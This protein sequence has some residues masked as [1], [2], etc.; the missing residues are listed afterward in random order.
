[1]SA[2]DRILVAV[3]ASSAAVG[4]AARLAARSGGEMLAVHVWCYDVPCC[5]PS[6]AECGLREDDRSL[7][8]AVCRLREAGV[9]CCGERWQTVDGRVT[10][11]LLAAADEYDASVVVVGST[12]PRGLRGR[13]RTGLGLRLARRCARPVLLVP[14]QRDSDE[15]GRQ[16]D[17]DSRQPV[18]DLVDSPRSRAQASTR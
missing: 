13:L 10:E 11:A 1:M 4:A 18:P 3:A 15:T 16:I 9:R 2:F 17:G 7:E 8:R 5:G 14:A 12:R 6:A